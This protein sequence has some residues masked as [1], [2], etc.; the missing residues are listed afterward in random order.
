MT[1][2]DKSDAK[3]YRYGAPITNKFLHG[4]KWPRHTHH[5]Y[6]LARVPDVT[7]REGLAVIRK[8]I[9]DHSSRVNA[10]YKVLRRYYLS[11]NDIN[12]KAPKSNQYLADNRLSHG[13]AEYVTTFLTGY[14][15]GKPVTYGNDDDAVRDL[16][17]DMTKTNNDASENLRLKTDLSIYGRAY[18]LVYVE[19]ND[20]GESVVRYGRVAPEQAFVVYDTSQNPRSL[21]GVRYYRDEINAYITIYTDNDTVTYYHEIGRGDADYRLMDVAPHRFGAVPLTEFHNDHMNRGSFER[22]LPQIDA[23]DLS[24]SELANF[25][26]DSNQALLVISGQP[27]NALGSDVMPDGSP[28]PN[29][30]SATFHN[31]MNDRFLVLGGDGTY[32]TADAKYVTKTYDTVGAESYKKRLFSDMLLMTLVPDMTDQAFGGVSS[33]VAMR[34]KLMG[35]D[36]RVVGPNELFKEGL[37]R[38]L[39]LAATIWSIRDGI[40]YD[41]INGTNITLT[42]NIP[43]DIE[44]STNAISTLSTAG[45]ISTETKADMAAPITGVSANDEMSRL[46][47][48]PDDDE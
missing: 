44:S 17:D 19:I 3:V 38:R 8:L 34:Y 40:K 31:A 39:R 26:E 4:R 42:P 29:G 11:D 48:E 45:A 25:E 14:T 18:E 36:Q 15:L 1:C 9:D 43:T 12:Y 23:Y 33:G 10:R 20:A 32:G 21:F 6:T 13:F 22:I 5:D 47:S 7:T 30:P 16:I 37:M 41:S 27:V 2:D 46:E 24:Q 28:N 35:S